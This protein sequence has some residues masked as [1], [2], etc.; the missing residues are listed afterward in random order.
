MLSTRPWSACKRCPISDL[1][2][3]QPDLQCKV[4]LSET[5]DKAL[6]VDQHPALLMPP[7]GA[8]K[9]PRPSWIVMLA[10]ALAGGVVAYLGIRVLIHAGLAEALLNADGHD[11][12]LV[13]G[14]LLLATW[15]S[16]TVHELGHLAGAVLSGLSPLML[17]SGPLQIEFRSDR[18][19][20]SF[21]RH[22]ATWGG[23]A[24]AIPGRSHGLGKR[25]AIWMVAGG[26]MASGLAALACFVLIP[27]T[28]GI[29]SL[30]ILQVGLLSAAIAMG[31]LIPLQSGGFASDGRQLWQLLRGNKQ[32][33]Q[34]LRLAA[35]IGRNFSGHRPAD[36]DFDE[37]QS[38]V[39]ESTQAMLKT[40]ALL[41]AAQVLDDRPDDQHAR[42]G[43]EALAKDLCAGGL[44]AYPLPFRA[45]LVLPIVIYL[46]QRCGN[47]DAAQRWLDAVP[48][49]VEEPHERL[50]AKSA[51]C[52]LRGE[53]AKAQAFALEALQKLSKNPPTGLRLMAKE[54][55]QDL[56]G[57]PHVGRP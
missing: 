10:S 50:H 54:R 33:L 35:I 46:A 30:W 52:K 34:R 6:A 56:A 13:I 32:A 9:A 27:S 5:F 25:Q 26:P 39:Q 37:L 36:W 16:I 14:G 40:S 28:G 44:A 31:T 7:D 47:A 20:G 42:A 22:R 53:A 51:I 41:L 15:I 55:L 23:L 17:F 11:W 19:Y 24:V 48:A 18:P 4:N 3:L 8:A 45:A 21:N 2:A 49:G 12:P 1:R 29:A 38:I 57:E 43:F